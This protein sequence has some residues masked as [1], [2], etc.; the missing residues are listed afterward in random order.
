M[1]NEKLLPSRSISINGN[2]IW[3]YDT[4]VKF[5][6]LPYTTG[7]HTYLIAGNVS[8][9][10]TALYSET[11]LLVTQINS[12]AKIKV[13]STGANNVFSTNGLD[14]YVKNGQANSPLKLYGVC[15]VLK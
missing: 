1:I 5:F 7:E 14:L 12:T 10:S 8:Y 2:V 11:I 9:I 13:I 6:T 15:Y 4:T 3:T